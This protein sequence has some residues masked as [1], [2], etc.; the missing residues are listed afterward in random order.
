VKARVVVAAALVLA[1]APSAWAQ[2]A[3]PALGDAKRC[4]VVVEDMGDVGFRI[5]DAQI[6]AQAAV[7]GLRKRLGSAAVVYG[8]VAA[9]A[10][11]MKQLLATPEGGGPQDGQ[12]KWFKA[13]DEASSWKVRARFGTSRG[14]HWITLSCRKK[15]ADVKD[16]VEEKRFEAKSFLE[17]RDQMA[18]AVPAF[19]PSGTSVVGVGDIPNEARGVDAGPVGMHKQEPLKPW[20]PPPRRD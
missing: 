3:A 9:S 17:A 16:V 13:C 11:A 19:C 4:V 6:V 10:S 8:G 7:A 12:I 20:T 18:A 1:C 14:T 15:G 2:S 5:S